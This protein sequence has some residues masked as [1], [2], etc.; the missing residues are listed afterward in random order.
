VHALEDTP[1]QYDYH[2]SLLSLP[3]LLGV[4]DEEMAVHEPYLYAADTE[5]PL[6]FLHAPVDAVKVGLFWD[7]TT[8]LAP[9]LPLLTVPNTYFYSVQQDATLS[10]QHHG[11]Q[12][13]ITDS[14][15]F[16]RD[17][18]ALATLIDQLD[19]VITVDSMVAH[20]AASM[21]ITTWLV[22]PPVCD[23]R[24]GFEGESTTLY[25]T[26]RLFRQQSLEKWDDVSIQLVKKL[27]G[28][29]G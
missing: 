25:P 14:S 8:T 29:V 13:I 24:W 19:V 21:G 2:A 22:V 20:L 3:F 5:T 9:F 12:G 4:T 18:T 6:E 15:P 7:D 27:Q 23:W 10:L 26:M 28:L 17:T 16:V 11:V 1:L